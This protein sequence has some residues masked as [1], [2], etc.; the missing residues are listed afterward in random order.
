MANLERILRLIWWPPSLVDAAMN[1]R[2]TAAVVAGVA[3]WLSVVVL[4]IVGLHDLLAG[5]I[6]MIVI[7]IA[8]VLAPLAM[9]ALYAIY[10]SPDTSTSMHRCQ[11][12]AV[13]LEPYCVIVPLFMWAGVCRWGSAIERSGFENEMLSTWLWAMVFVLSLYPFWAWRKIATALDEKRCRECGYMLIGL[14]ARR[15]PECGREF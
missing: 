11:L 13:L 4:V 10:Y 1:V 15:C 6:A 12:R 14:T 2:I 3:G 5:R 9:L 7:A 8:L